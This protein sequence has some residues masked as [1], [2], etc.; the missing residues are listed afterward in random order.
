MTQPVLG[1]TVG[2]IIGAYAVGWLCR[3]L[4]A[5]RDWQPRTQVSAIYYS[6]VGIVV[7]TGSAIVTSHWWFGI[8]DELVGL[9]ATVGVPEAAVGI[10][11]ESITVL[12]VLLAFSA[13]VLSLHPLWVETTGHE[14]SM[15]QASATWICIAILAVALWIGFDFVVTGQSLLG[16]LGLLLIGSLGACIL[17]YLGGHRLLAMDPES[18]SPTDDERRRVEQAFDPL[19]VEPDRIVLASRGELEAPVKIRGR[20]GKRWV[21]LDKAF[22]NELSPRELGITIAQAEGLYRRQL[23]LRYWLTLWI[24]LGGLLA[25]LSLLFGWLANYWIV[26]LWILFAF[27]AFALHLWTGIRVFAYADD[28]AAKTYGVDAVRETYERHGDT[29]ANSFKE[30]PGYRLLTEGEPVSSRINRLESN[31]NRAQ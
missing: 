4:I 11:A 29:L 12:S 1:L 14:V 3:V 13:T 24:F 23:E 10:L 19:Q 18:R 21:F 25:S 28:L 2:L 6:G 5:G 20:P 17:A 31:E 22:L 30:V 8:R 9:L 27:V 26:V 15:A 7:V 16:P